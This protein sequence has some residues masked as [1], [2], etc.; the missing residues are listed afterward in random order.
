MGT[1]V[2]VP[3]TIRAAA[4]GAAA[5]MK[6][7][8]N[9]PLVALELPAA[10]ASGRSAGCSSGWYFDSVFCRKMT[11]LRVGLMPAW[12]SFAMRSLMK[13]YNLE[14]PRKTATMDATAEQAYATIWAVVIGAAASVGTD[15]PRG[16]LWEEEQGRQVDSEVWPDAR[17]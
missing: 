5:V 7:W 6:S 13:G 16:Q 11:R 3:V 2:T 10:A 17:A 4:A 14:N 15:V 8:G 1:E 12:R 9:R